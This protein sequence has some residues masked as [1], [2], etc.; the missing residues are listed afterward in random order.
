MTYTPTENE[1]EMNAALIFPDNKELQ[2]NFILAAYDT[3][4]YGIRN[5]D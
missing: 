4:Y 5:D 1:I 2:S 3:I